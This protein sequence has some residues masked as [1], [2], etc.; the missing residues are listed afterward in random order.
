LIPGMNRIET[1]L[2]PL[3]AGETRIGVALTAELD[4]RSTLS[5]IVTA[6][7]G[8]PIAIVS[9][10]AEHGAAFARLA[11]AAMPGSSSDAL[12]EL[13]VIQP[14]S[15]SDYLRNWLDYDAIVLLNIPARAV[16]SRKA[17][18]IETAV[19]R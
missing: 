12:S 7:P 5:A 13:R 6:R 14:G 15:A 17:G 16:S 8:R 1:E 10:D 3:S 9:P 19:T 11:G 4:H 2:P 18:L